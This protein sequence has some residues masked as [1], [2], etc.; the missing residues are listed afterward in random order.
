MTENLLEAL[1]SRPIRETPDVYRREE[2]AERIK[3]LIN[4]CP[5][6]QKS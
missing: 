4:P 6:L 2:I 3:H 1:A 5:S